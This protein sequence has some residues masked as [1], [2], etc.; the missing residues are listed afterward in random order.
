MRQF[1]AKILHSNQ[2]DMV[3]DGVNGK[4]FKKKVELIPERGD[5]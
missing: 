4:F 3:M 2:I 5:L 1:H